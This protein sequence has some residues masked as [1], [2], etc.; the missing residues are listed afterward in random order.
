M[1]VYDEPNR[2]TPSLFNSP[3][4]T[5]GVFDGFHIGHRH[6]IAR[7]LTEAGDA[8]SVVFT[9]RRHPK[10]VLGKTPPTSIM[11]L[12]HRLLHLERAGVDACVIADF[13][14]LASM[15]AS[16]FVNDIL[17][18]RIGIRTLVLGFDSAFG[19]DREGDAAFV[20]KNFPSIRVVSAD[21][22]KLDGILVSSSLIRR[23]ILDGK[24][25]D[26][27]H[28]LGHPVSLYGEVL[29]GSGRGTSL[30]YPTANIFPENET[31]PPS[32]VYASVAILDD[33]SR[34]LSVT[35]IGVRPTFSE[36]E[37][38]IAEVHIL[39]F[40]RLLYGT[41][42]EVELHRF[43]REERKFADPSELIKQIERD[44]ARI[45]EEHNSR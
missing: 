12:P 17:I 32:G 25:E 18:K 42:I 20:R 30:G 11:S 4:L 10:A 39:D 16:Q 21:P 3:S 34:H 41:R 37:R 31:L 6:L 33:G 26:A 28:L 27:A 44:I 38:K 23:M 35:N 7:L 22:V 40:D 15:S 9:F 45:R 5:I 8:D 29:K 43:I 36:M 1:R 19:K 13:E 2:L 14:D 24:I